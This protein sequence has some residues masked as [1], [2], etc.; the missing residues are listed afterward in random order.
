MQPSHDPFLGISGPAGNVELSWSAGL[1][2]DPALSF[3][4]K[5]EGAESGF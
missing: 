5:P 1:G 4:K 3:L 2:S